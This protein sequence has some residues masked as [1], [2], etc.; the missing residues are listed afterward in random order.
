MLSPMPENQIEPSSKDLLPTGDSCRGVL[1]GCRRC[2]ALVTKTTIARD[3][4]PPSRAHGHLAGW[5]G[6]PPF[7]VVGGHDVHSHTRSNG[8]PADG[9]ALTR[10]RDG[11]GAPYCP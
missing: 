11:V 3:K 7:T 10:C 9:R 2:A 6:E 5:M 1:A 4:A 8:V